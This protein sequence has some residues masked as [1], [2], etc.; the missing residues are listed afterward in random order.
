MWIR[1]TTHKIHYYAVLICKIMV[2]C[3]LISKEDCE[4]LQNALY[5]KRNN[6]V[7]IENNV[8]KNSEKFSKEELEI[9]VEDCIG[10][11]YVLS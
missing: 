1:K 2:K 11:L 10:I 5:H 8:D 3:C 4:S 7:V 9:Y 6:L